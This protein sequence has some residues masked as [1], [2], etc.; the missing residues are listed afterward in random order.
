MKSLIKT[1]NNLKGCNAMAKGKMKP[2]KG[3]S[4]KKAC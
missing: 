1:R 2:G 3:K 4:G